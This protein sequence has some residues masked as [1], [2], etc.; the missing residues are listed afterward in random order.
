MKN[1]AIQ[2]ILVVRNDRFGEFLLNIPAMRA[3]KET[4]KG[5]KVIAMVN[6]YV[7]ELAESVPFIDEIIVWSEG[8]HSFS[9]L[10]WLISQLK[11]RKIDMA[12]MLNPSKELNILTF[13]TGI[14]IRV[15]YSKKWGFLLTHKIKDEKR[16]EK[17]HEV[18][19]N[20]ELVGLTGAKTENRSL[21]IDI[22]DEFSTDL[23]DFP[24]GNQDLLALHP[25]TSD[26]IKQWPIEN[27]SNLSSE[28]AKQLNAKVIIIGGKDELSKGSGIFSDLGKDIINLTGK[29]S[30]VQ[31][32]SLLKKCK[33][34]ISGDSGPVHLAACVGIPVVAIF[35]SDIPGKSSKRWGPCGAGNAVI[36]KPSLSQITVEEVFERVK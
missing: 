8:K 23:K 17:K 28:L 25:W 5:A 20:L 27:F 15:G 35:R 1:K 7:K 11:Y 19:Y 10:F 30:L 18:D 29:T 33:L 6:P 16:F 34:L 31:L 36:E 13:F 9:K 26:S 12:V 2:N 21:F 4:Y 24:A 3:L 22:N 32:A 14:P